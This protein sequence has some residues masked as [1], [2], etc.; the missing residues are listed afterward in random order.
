VHTQHSA[1]IIGSG[2]RRGFHRRRAYYSGREDGRQPSIGPT[3]RSMWMYS[4]L[5]VKINHPGR[6]MGRQPQR[7]TKETAG[8]L[9]PCA[10]ALGDP[11]Q[12]THVATCAVLQH[13]GVSHA[14][15][16]SLGSRSCAEQA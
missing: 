3:P 8:G 9:E 15:I 5:V 13:T 2:D 1:I 4:P 12:P 14:V 10:F 11:P 16:L 6:R 7:R